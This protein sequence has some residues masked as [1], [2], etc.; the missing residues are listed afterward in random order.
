MSRGKA[1]GKGGTGWTLDPDGGG[2]RI[3]EEVRGL[4]SLSPV[5]Y[6]LACLSG[7][8]LGVAG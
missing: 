5:S 2:V 3:P 1:K 7:A 8:T 4:L 6:M